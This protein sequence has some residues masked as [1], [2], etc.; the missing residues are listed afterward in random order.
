M[1]PDVYIA[2]LE[3]RNR[4]LNARINATLAVLHEPEHLWQCECCTRAYEALVPIRRPR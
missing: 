3:Q 1:S 4:D 2:F